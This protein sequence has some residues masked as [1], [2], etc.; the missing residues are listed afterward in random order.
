[1]R[2]TPT[3]LVTTSPKPEHA[4][5]L[6]SVPP[7]VPSD[8]L[9][10]YF[11]LPIPPSVPPS[12]YPSVRP[13]LLIS[14]SQFVCVSASLLF[15]LL[16]LLLSASLSLH[17]SLPPHLRPPIYSSIL[18]SIPFYLCLSLPTSVFMSLCLII[19]YN[20]PFPPIPPF[21]SPSL[22]PW[23]SASVLPSVCA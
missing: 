6:P 22:H 9:F 17:L 5:V 11:C 3:T 14:V 10:V 12:P 21:V 15:R 8:R 2:P 20:I 13:S 18:Q 4:P 16:S 23:I 19:R 7:P 1:M